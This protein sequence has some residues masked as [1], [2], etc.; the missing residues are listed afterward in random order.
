M[1]IASSTYPLDI[2][3]AKSSQRYYAML[4]YEVHDLW[5]LSP[6]ELGGM[7]PKHP[8]IMLMQRAENQC[9]KSSDYVVSL[10]PC[11]KGDMLEH[12]MAD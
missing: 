7:S 6:I 11:A 8:Y 12:G 1:V 10:L 9:Y 3:P 5:P 4:I 2:Y